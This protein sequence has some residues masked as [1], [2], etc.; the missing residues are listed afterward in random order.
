MSGKRSCFQ[1]ARERIRRRAAGPFPLW[2][3]GG[4]VAGVWSE[5]ECTPCVVKAVWFREAD[6][7][8][9]STVLGVAG[10]H[11]HDGLRDAGFGGHGEAA[12]AA[13]DAGEGHGV[14]SDQ[15]EGRTRS[16]QGWDLEMR[17]QSKRRPRL[18]RVW[19]TGVG[20]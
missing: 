2:R 11:P 19:G 14:D 15:A 7:A 10:L 18:W 13:A 8:P 4:G 20:I 9:C 17:E 1:R 3:R 16:G 6:V 5:A 12:H